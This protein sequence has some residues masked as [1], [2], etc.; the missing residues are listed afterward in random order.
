MA[1]QESGISSLGLGTLQ[2][3]KHISLVRKLKVAFVKTPSSVVTKPTAGRKLSKDR[4]A[5][6]KFST[7]H[8]GFYIYVS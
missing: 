5:V 2:S 7:L 6:E 1:L 3:S 8:T 4:L